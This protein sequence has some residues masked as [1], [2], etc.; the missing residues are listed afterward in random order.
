MQLNMPAVIF[1]DDHSVMFFLE[2]I[3]RAT[4]FDSVMRGSDQ[5]I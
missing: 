3:Q 4:D 2:L 5:H 1:L